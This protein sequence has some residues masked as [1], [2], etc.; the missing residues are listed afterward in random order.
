MPADSLSICTVTT[1]VICSLIAALKSR[2]LVEVAVSQSGLPKGLP[3]RGQPDDL[4]ELNKG[5]NGA[6]IPR[7]IELFIGVGARTVIERALRARRASHD[8]KGDG[9]QGSDHFLIVL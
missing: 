8:D 6:D 3:E 9:Q 1:A 7:Q 2:P 5:V 4:A